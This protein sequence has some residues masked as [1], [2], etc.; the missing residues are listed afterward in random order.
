MKPLTE[1][2]L[3]AIEAS[4]LIRM[5]MREGKLHRPI[6]GQSTTADRLDDAVAAVID[7]LVSNAEGMSAECTDEL[8]TLR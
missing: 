3:S 2:I 4:R 7:E 6:N 5:M 8:K 1:L